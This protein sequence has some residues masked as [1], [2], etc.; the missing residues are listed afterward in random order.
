MDCA[1]NLMD[2]VAIATRAALFD[3]RVPKTEIQD[4]GDGEYE[5]EVMDDVEDAEP[6]PGLERLPV[7]MSL[8]KVGALDSVREIEY[9]LIQCGLD[10][11]PVYC[12]SH[13]LGRTVLTGDLDCGR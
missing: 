9:S 3:T 4:L 1:G 12:G 10:W 7:S 8:Y 11:R 2:C 13:Y 5:F 6:I